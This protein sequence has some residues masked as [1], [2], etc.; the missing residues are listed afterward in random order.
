[1]ANSRI[2]TSV[3]PR[4]IVVTGTG[5]AVGK[6]FVSVEIL[7][8]L[9]SLG[10]SCSGLKPIETGYTHPADSDAAALAGAAGHTLVT[11][12]F[13]SPNAESPHRAARGRG[14]T[15]AVPAVASW[16]AD[17]VIT[18]RWDAVL[19]ETAGGLFSPLSE[20]TSNL[21]IVRALEPCTFVLIAPDRLGALH[22][23]LC[24][25]TAARAVHRAPDLICMNLQDDAALPLENFA[26]LRRFVAC[27]PV[28]QAPLVRF[29]TQDVVAALFGPRASDATPQ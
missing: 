10:L 24:A 18:A 1:M 13:T 6:T 28:I 20:S 17:K 27:P 16:V 26:E 25:V 9:S 23:V 15:I 8:T 19:V 21:D 4:R 29:S 5:T 3:S 12:Y 7:R 14:T 11:P 2:T 22:D